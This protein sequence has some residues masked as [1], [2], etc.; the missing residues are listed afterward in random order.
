MAFLGRDIGVEDG[1]DVH[2]GRLIGV[3]PDGGLKLVLRDGV[4]VVL[5]SGSLFL[6]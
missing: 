3:A 1:D 2:Q 4:K 5:Y 6:L